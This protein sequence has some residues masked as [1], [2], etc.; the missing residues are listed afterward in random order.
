MT[1]IKLKG[2]LGNQLF[3]YAYGRNLELSGEKIVFDTSF[4]TGN[5]AKKD[6]ARDF[7]LN[8]FNIGTKAQF[9]DKKRPILSLFIKVK[10]KLGFSHEDYYQSQKYFDNVTGAIRQDFKLRNKMNSGAEIAYEAI[11]KAPVSVSVHIRRGDYV[12]NA[13]IN[14]YHGSCSPEYY[15]KAI[16]VLSGKL[17]EGVAGKIHLFVFSDDIDWVKK[18]LS[19]P[20]PTT[21]VSNPA[22]PDYE[23]LVLMSKCMHHI[24]ANSSFSWWGAWL[25]PNPQKIVIAPTKWTNADPKTYKDIVPNPWIKI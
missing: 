16:D 13:K 3:Q 4:Y 15:K 19:F 24:I 8:N 2:G 20:Y 9:V 6:T 7:K 10:R 23:E 12:Q 21:Y 18:N 11:Q 1:I 5:K 17:D 22:I 14:Q 25:N